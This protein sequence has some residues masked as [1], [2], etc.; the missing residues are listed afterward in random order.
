M[1]AIIVV[2]FAGMC[3][4]QWYVPGSMIFEQQDVLRHG[5]QF[6]FKTAPVDPTDPF[7]GKYVTLSFDAEDGFRDDQEWNGGEDV[8][9]VIEKDNA[10]F[11]RIADIV[12][13]R[14]G[15]DKDYFA[16]TVLYSYDGLTRIRVPFDRFYLEESKASEAERIYWEGARDSTQNVYAVVRIKAGNT[17][18]EDVRIDDRSIVDIVREANQKSK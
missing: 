2:A 18:L 11:A 15:D 3:L 1:K 16:T 6:Y 4:A 13:S 10:G 7:R 17:V 9:V 12:A 5:N 8:F 14:P